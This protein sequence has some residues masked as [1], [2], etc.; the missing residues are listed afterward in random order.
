MLLFVLIIVQSY[1]YLT[2]FKFS[3]FNINS[4]IF[5]VWIFNFPQQVD[6][7][8]SRHFAIKFTWLDKVKYETGFS[9]SRSQ[10]ALS[11]VKVNSLLRRFSLA[12]RFMDK[13]AYTPLL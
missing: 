5:N 1:L 2:L 8:F 11:H 4:Y 10:A 7:Y 12:D 9:I 13:K 3:I 6:L